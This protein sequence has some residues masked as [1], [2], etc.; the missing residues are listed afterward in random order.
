M[1]GPTFVHVW[2]YYFKICKIYIKQSS[3]KIL[4]LLKIFENLYLI[5]LQWQLGNTFISV[6]IV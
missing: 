1:P 2:L 4:S 3:N 6:C 5:Y